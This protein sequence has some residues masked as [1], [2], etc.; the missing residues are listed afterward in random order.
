VG[1]FPPTNSKT[2]KMKD[3]AWHKRKTS[4]YLT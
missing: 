3:F 2:I 1:V 4:A